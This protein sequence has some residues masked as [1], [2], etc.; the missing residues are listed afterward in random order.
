MRKKSK[1]RGG[2]KAKKKER[3]SSLPR[4][5]PSAPLAESSLDDTLLETCRTRLQHGDWESLAAVTMDEVAKAGSCEKV[6]LLVAVGHAQLGDMAQARQFVQ[7]ALAWKC[8]RTIA[9]RVLLG[10]VHNSLARSAAALGDADDAVAHF[11]ESVSLV[12]PRADHRLLARTRHV[13]EASRLGLLPEAAELI[14]RAAENI[15]KDPIDPTHQLAIIRSDISLLK[16][17]LSIALMR[18]QIYADA[19]SEHSKNGL[20]NRAVSQLGQDIWVLERSNYKRNGF[21][22]EFG[23]TDGVS[24]NNTWLLETEFGWSGICAEPNPNFFAKLEKNRRCTVSDACIY[25]TSGEVVEFILAD[26]YGGIADFAAS[27]DH[28][29]KRMAYKAEGEVLYLET[30]SLDDFLTAHNAPREI[31]YM[32]I[33]TEGSELAILSAFP[34]EKWQIRLLTIE[35]NFTPARAEIRALLEGH[36]YTCTE[37]QFDDWYEL[38][39]PK[40]PIAVG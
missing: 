22:V 16:H 26:V 7:K 40:R 8:D 31:D 35:H 18:N 13:R 14:E 10:S 36:G 17:E 33:D 1:T 3:G 21:F 9:A 27:D 5:L 24:L 23:A 32:S 20:A 2:P 4:V 19:G 39:E 29:D 25:A 34:F 6:A 28:T 30:V 38:T 11:T 37:R 15:A 12:E